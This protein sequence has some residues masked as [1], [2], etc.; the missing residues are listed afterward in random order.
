MPKSIIAISIL[1]TKDLYVREIHRYLLYMV[2]Q[3]LVMSLCVINI[4]ILRKN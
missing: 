3:L 2:V 4:H 1:K